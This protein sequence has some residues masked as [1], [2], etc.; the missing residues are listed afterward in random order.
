MGLCFSSAA[1][2]RV[3]NDGK[4]SIPSPVKAVN[5]GDRTVAA[6]LLN[7]QHSS[8]RFTAAGSRDEAFYDSQPWLESDAEDDYLSVRGDFTPSLG[9]TPVHNSTSVIS[10]ETNKSLIS[11]PS[12]SSQEIKS[13]MRLLE[14]FKESFGPKDLTTEAETKSTTSNGSPSSFSDRHRHSNGKAHED[15]EEEG[16]KPSKSVAECCFPI[17]RSSPAGRRKRTSPTQNQN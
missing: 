6:L 4:D 2:P 16:D 15:E 12:A 11:F 14:L 13:R 1:R 17:S 10:T 9:S 7:S 3:L 8:G 5:G